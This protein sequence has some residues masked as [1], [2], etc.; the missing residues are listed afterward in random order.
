MKTRPVYTGRTWSNCVSFINAVKSDYA[1]SAGT[2]ASPESRNADTGVC[3][4]ESMIHAADIAD[5]L[6]NTYLVGEKYL[7]PDHYELTNE[8][9]GD[10][11]TAFM[12]GNADAL[13]ST[14]P[15]QALLSDQPGN[16][17]RH[18]FGSAHADSFNM[19]FCDGSVHAMSY[20]VDAT[21]RP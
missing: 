4:Y 17:V 14:C 2:L 6:S 12:G 8:D 20:S 15:P 11:D 13:R 10:D 9:G 18:Q 3:F 1:A 19:A 7:S 16:L 21:N 5:G